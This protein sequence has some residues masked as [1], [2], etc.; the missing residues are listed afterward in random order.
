MNITDKSIYAICITIIILSGM[1]LIVTGEWLEIK[2]NWGS[3]TSSPAT[4]P[5]Q[6]GKRMMQ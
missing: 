1:K 6:P 2:T 3:A 5:F 4:E